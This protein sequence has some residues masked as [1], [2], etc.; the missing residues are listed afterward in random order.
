[1]LVQAEDKWL[2]VDTGA[3]IREMLGTISPPHPS[4]RARIFLHLHNICWGG[5]DRLCFLAIHNTVS[6]QSFMIDVYSLG[7]TAFSTPASDGTTTF[8]T[9]LESPTIPKCIFGVQNELAS[10]YRGFGVR[11]R[12]VHDVQK[13]RPANDGTCALARRDP[14]RK[15]IAS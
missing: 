13:R 3:S 15:A 14:C 7:A 1:M 4:T 12:C 9:I 10:L 8:K 11:I 5:Q 2:L 6:S